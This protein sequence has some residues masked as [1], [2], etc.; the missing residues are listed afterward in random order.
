[1]NCNLIICFKVFLRDSE[2]LESVTASQ[3]AFLAN[4]DLGVNDSYNNAISCILLH[5]VSYVYYR[6]LLMRLVY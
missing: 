4:D 1:M 5:V 2:T 3:E 6:I